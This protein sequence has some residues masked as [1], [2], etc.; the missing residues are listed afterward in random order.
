MNLINQQRWGLIAG[1]LAALSFGL[2]APLISLVSRSSSP[3]VIA[4]LLYLGAGL[5]LLLVRLVVPKSNGECGVQR[6]DLPSLL[7][8]TALGGIVG[9]ICLVQ[10]LSLLSA[11]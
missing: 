8:L 5:A 7:G 4:A 3:L 9:P 11:G 10:G 1:L 6:R 2:S